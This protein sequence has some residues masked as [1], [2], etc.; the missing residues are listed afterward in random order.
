MGEKGEMIEIG[1]LHAHESS[2]IRRALR[3]LPLLR[4]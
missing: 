1:E 2:L 3:T 4:M